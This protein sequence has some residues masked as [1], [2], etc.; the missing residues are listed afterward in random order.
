MCDYEAQRH[1]YIAFLEAKPAS[2]GAAVPQAKD[3]LSKLATC[4]FE[5]EYDLAA[6]RAQAESELYRALDRSHKDVHR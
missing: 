6:R 1:L 4:R 5:A 3:E 2:R